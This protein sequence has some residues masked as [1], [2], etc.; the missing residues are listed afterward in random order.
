MNRVYIR[1]HL[2]CFVGWLV[3]RNIS[4]GTWLSIASGPIIIKNFC[5]E[6]RKCHPERRNFALDTMEA[7]IVISFVYLQKTPGPGT[8]DKTYQT[9]M[10][11]TIKK[12]GRSYGLF[13]TCGAYGEYWVCMLPKQNNSSEVLRIN[14][15]CT[16]LY[17]FNT[18]NLIF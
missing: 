14:Y 2:K 6:Y 5:S 7:A 1:K 3:A 18:D 9:P 11:D 8:Y 17:C 16:T 13:F 15:F 4:L 10:P 12:M